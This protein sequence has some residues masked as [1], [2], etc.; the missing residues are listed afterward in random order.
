MD[1]EAIL[2]S[3][4]ES[5][6]DPE[7]FQEILAK[8]LIER[9]NNTEYGA[10]KNAIEE[11][12][13]A[14]YNALKSYLNE[15]ENG[16]INALLT[17]PP[18]FWAMTRGTTSKSKFIPI[19]KTDLEEKMKCGPRVFCAYLLQKMRFDI[20]G[21][22]VLNL[23]FPSV[24]GKMKDGKEYGYSSGFYFKTHTAKYGIDI[25]PDQEKI[26]P[27]IGLSKKDW[28]DRF[29]LAYHE[30]LGKNITMITGVTQVMT[31]FA[32]FV[33]KKHGKYPKQLW[34]T[35]VLVCSSTAGI[36]TKLKP[37]LKALYG[38][39]DIL[40]VYGATE[41][42]YGQQFDRPCVTPNYDIYYFEVEVKGK[43]KM[44]HEMKKREIGKLIIS[45][46]LFPRYKIG[47]LIKCNG[48]PYFTVIGR[49]RRFTVLRHYVE[50][51]FY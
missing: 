39:V 11:F 46:S 36:N 50:S 20:L 45:S 22:T 47:D 25:V 49:D 37:A 2:S 27:L 4:F 17:E 15:V 35:N 23:N 26:D 42:I 41:G 6:D 30:A 31:Q 7:A 14:D 16:N 28:E 3:W 33:K 48:S 9:Y 24:L 1:I 10:G 44:L 40:E 5:I 18:L 8:R 34:D 13:V 21:G 12:P 19:T 38:N 43:I 29:D 32:T 51:F